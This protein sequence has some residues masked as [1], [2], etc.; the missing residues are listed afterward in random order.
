MSY[1]T[2]EEQAR[3]AK[4]KILFPN[5]TPGT[6]VPPLYTL[7]GCGVMLYGS[8]DHDRDTQSYVTTLFFT[9]VFLPLFP[10]KAYRVVKASH[11]SY[12]FLGTEPLSGLC[13][14]YRLVVACVAIFFIATISWSSHVNSEPYKNRLVLKHGKELIASKQWLDATTEVLPLLHDQSFGAEAQAIVKE[15]TTGVFS[16]DPETLRIYLFAIANDPNRDEIVPNFS[17]RL[18]EKA[19]SYSADQPAAAMSLLDLASK[20]LGDLDPAKVKEARMAIS[21]SWWQSSPQDVNA[22]CAYVIERE[23]T[24]EEEKQREILLPH[25][26][27]S[28]LLDSEAARILG[29]IL[30]RDERFAEA[31][32]LLSRYTTPRMKS[33]HR[34]VDH[35]QATLESRQS[36]Y[37]SQL[38]RR[39][40]PASFYTAYEKADEAEQS[41]LVNDYLVEKFKTD[42]QV[43]QA[44]AEQEDAGRMV[45]PVMQLGITELNLS[46]AA[47][48][49]EARTSMLQSAEKTFLSIRGAVGDTDEYRLFLGEISYWLGKH[50]EGKKLFDELLAANQRSSIWLME[51]AQR[52]RDVGE[53][54]VARSMLEEAWTKE[55]DTKTKASIAAFRQIMADD[56]KDR[57]LWLGRCDQSQAYIKT[58]IH[59]NKAHVAIE[60]GRM[61]DAISDYKNALEEY[62]HVGDSA[63][64]FNNEALVWQGISQL[65]GKIEDF[66]SGVKLMERSLRLEQS[67]ITMGNLVSAYSSLSNWQLNQKLFDLSKMPEFSSSGMFLSLCKKPEDYQTL[68]AE[69]LALPEMDQAVKLSRQQQVMAPKS[70]Q[71]YASLANYYAYSKNETELSALL[72]QIVAAKM[73]FAE[74]LA[75]TKKYY[76]G[77]FSEEDR[78]NLEKSISSRRKMIQGFPEGD[79]SPSCIILE[80]YL[81]E[82]ENALRH[83]PKEGTEESVAKL[84]ERAQQLKQRLNCS[85]TNETL[86]E[87]L[88]ESAVEKLRQDAEIE[89]LYRSHQWSFSAEDFLTWLHINEKYVPKLAALAEVKQAYA[90]NE[91]SQKIAGNEASVQQWIWSRSCAPDQTSALKQ[92]IVDAKWRQLLVQ[93]EYEL[94]PYSTNNILYRHLLAIAMDDPAKAKEVLDVAKAQGIPYGE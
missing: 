31:Q 2:P 90:V 40:A 44:L 33:F 35:Y 26:K 10:I 27:N 72:E 32:T 91:E 48:S 80:T 88:C 87:M 7:N 28:F 74:P 77:E 51:V 21:Q 6:K 86:F 47:D 45:A 75:E 81:L 78:S 49:A 60:E 61:N 76:A 59:E 83:R 73:N 14:G 54:D 11:N 84:L 16:A 71:A 65:T 25:V 29:G 34:A 57:L 46:R 68:V 89:A 38:D 63:S 64:K 9:L 56:S 23:D 17:Q 8:R 4:L 22:A 24:L 55:A 39:M 79:S 13:K 50:E 62:Q 12:Y 66:R 92:R 30:F 52:L 69:Y 53:H 41:R 67:A 18:L 1:T 19:Q 70:P 42:A 15:A 85:A 36:F 37:I 3:Q 94:A 5:M 43:Q 58:A 93:V 20:H 82:D